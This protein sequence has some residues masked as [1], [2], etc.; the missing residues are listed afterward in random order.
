[1]KRSFI[2]FIALYIGSACL[3]PSC[4]IF[5]ECGVCEMVTVK[6]DGSET[7]STPVPLCGEDL[8]D[9]QNFIPEIVDGNTIYWECE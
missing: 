6:P 9:K 5:D 4:D 8:T 2:S 3:L 7:R 1:M